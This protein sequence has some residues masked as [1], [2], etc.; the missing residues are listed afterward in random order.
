MDA[1]REVCSSA[2]SL[3]KAKKLRVRLPLAELTVATPN[4]DALRRFESLIADEVNVKS[5]TFVEDVASY[6]DQTLTLVP[7]VLGPR[8]ERTFNESLKR[9]RRAI[10][11]PTPTE[12]P[13]P[14]SFW[15]TASMS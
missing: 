12:S 2:L 13:P 11:P 6:C 5:V 8:S 10:G 14:T 9:S 15:R 4:A 3:R 7:R 1:V